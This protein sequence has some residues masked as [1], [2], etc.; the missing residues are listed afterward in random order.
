MRLFRLLDHPRTHALAVA[1][2]CVLGTSEIHGP[3]P[4]PTGYQPA[5]PVLSPGTLEAVLLFTSRY[6]SH[7]PSVTLNHNTC[8]LASA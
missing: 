8:A 2:N 5:E 3:S 6:V 7:Q 4:L 1:A